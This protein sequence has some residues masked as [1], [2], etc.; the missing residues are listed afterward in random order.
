MKIKKN[1]LAILIHDFLIFILFLVFYCEANQNIYSEKTNLEMVWFEIVV[2][3]MKCIEENFVYLDRN[4]SMQ[5]RIDHNFCSGRTSASC[6]N[7]FDFKS[8]L[9]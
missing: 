2:T 6:C 9:E 1:V 3:R 8:V 4:L 7:K 5:S